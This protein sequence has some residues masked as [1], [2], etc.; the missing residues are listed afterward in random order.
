MRSKSVVPPMP[1]EV[2]PAMDAPLRSSTASFDNAATI[3][4]FSMRMVRRVL[5]SEQNH[6]F[7]ARA[8]HVA[9]ANGQ[10]G[11]SG[12]RFLQQKFDTFLHG[13][14]VMDI[15]VPGFLD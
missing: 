2:S 9:C 4:A 12:T 8:A 3:W 13:A 15:F 11:I 14:I 6:E 10:H 1:S 5:R 7:V